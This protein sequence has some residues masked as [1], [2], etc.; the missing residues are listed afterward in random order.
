MEDKERRWESDAADEPQIY[1]PEK[2]EGRWTFSRRAFLALAAAAAAGAV[3]D[4]IPGARGLLG[5][6]VQLVAHA[7]E[8]SQET[9]APG[10]PFAKIWRLKNNAVQPWGEGA[11]LRLTG[12]EEW[13]ATSSI[14]LPNL[15]PG[16]V[17]NVRVPMVAPVKLEPQPVK[18]AVK[19]AQGDYEFFLP[20]VYRAPTDLPCTCDAHELCTCDSY[21]PPCTCDSDAPCTCDY[22]VPCT[23][24]YHICPCDYEVPC[25]CDLDIPCTC[26]YDCGCVGDTCPTFCADCGCVGDYCSCVYDYGCGCV[27]DYCTCV[28]DYCGCV[29]F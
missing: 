28:Y 25:V 18:A 13:Q 6:P 12:A 17:T 10:Q 15:A 23:C 2:E 29:Y 21:T 7:T 5:R 8:L 24:D 3:A 19:I 20:T 4:G 9:L 11:L 22:D 1:K 14:P 26:D 27:G 16:Q